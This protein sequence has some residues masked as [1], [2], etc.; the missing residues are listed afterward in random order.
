MFKIRPFRFGTWPPTKG[1]RQA[2]PYTLAKQSDRKSVFNPEPKNLMSMKAKE[3]IVKEIM[4]LAD[5]IKANPE[6]PETLLTD[7][8]QLY[9]MAVLL[10]HLP[11]STPIPSEKE[12]RRAEPAEDKVAETQ[13]IE[14]DLFSTEASPATYRTETA[15]VKQELP[16]SSPVDNKTSEKLQQNRVEDLKSYIGINDKFRFINELFDG[17]IK[18]Y[19]VAIDQINSFGNRDEAMS[20]INNLESVYKWTPENTMADNFKELV[21]KKF[22]TAGQ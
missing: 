7:A 20:Y 14:M 9:E 2:N 16:V 1:S 3:H 15:E 19:N 18:E 22:K 11:E 6:Q 12:P 5:R 17:N 8:A 13:Q 4:D 10:K 21:Q